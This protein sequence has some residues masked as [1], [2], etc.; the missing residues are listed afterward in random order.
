MSEAAAEVRSGRCLCGRV[1]F[2]ALGPAV[3]VA[4]CYCRDC[5]RLSGA[6]HTT[7]AMFPAGAVVVSGQAAEYSLRSDAGNTVTRVFCP[8]CGS[9]LL[10][11]NTGMAGFV[12][13][14][15]GL[16]DDPSSFQP[17]VAIFARSRCAWD[18]ED[19]AVT[20]FDAQPE[21]RPS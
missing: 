17:E 6:G 19:A 1:S 11:R 4:H 5:Q 13:I 21:W 14:S 10:G 18:R 20:T 15:L 8:S 9:P 12:T 2:D 16:F 3:V 7:G